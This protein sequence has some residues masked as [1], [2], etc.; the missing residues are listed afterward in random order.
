[1]ALE[2]ILK[3]ATDQIEKNE[4]KK[5][6]KI[7]EA[8]DRSSAEYLA[9]RGQPARNWLSNEIITFL[10][11]ENKNIPPTPLDTVI[12]NR[13]LDHIANGHLSYVRELLWAELIHAGYSI[14]NSSRR[15]SSV[16][17][18]LT[19]NLLM[20]VAAGPTAETGTLGEVPQE[21]IKRLMMIAVSSKFRI[22]CPNCYREIRIWDA[23][24]QLNAFGPAK[25]QCSQCNTILPTYLTPWDK[26][27]TKYK[28]KTFIWPFLFIFGGILS[29]IFLKIDVCTFMGGASIVIGLFWAFQ[30]WQQGRVSLKIPNW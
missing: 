16:Y 9:Q 8:L 14:E 2:L 1:M 30:V 6:S 11:T 19:L 10:T 17:V 24:K 13:I 28:I 4:E 26:T 5:N 20:A 15:G 23:H 18:G 25:I 29:M 3:I 7:I 12:V 27:T 21:E 22:T